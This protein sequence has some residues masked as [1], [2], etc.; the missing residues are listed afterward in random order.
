L[1]DWKKYYTENLYPLQN[2]VLNCVKN[3][4]TRFFLTGGTALSRGYF[5]HRYSDD[6]DFFTEND[7]EFR[8]Q[9]EIVMS[10]L[11]TS[12]FIIESDTI[13][14]SNDYISCYVKSGDYNGIK[15]KIDMVNDVA[16]RFGDIIETPVYFRTDDWRNILSNKLCALLRLEAKDYAD[17]LVISQ[18][19]I[20]NWGEVID[21]ARE[22]E[23]GLDPALLADLLV[24]I[25]KQHFDTI[26]WVIPQFWDQFK[27]DMDII[28]HDMIRGADNSL[29]QK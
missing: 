1:N 26:K 3:S 25:P 7:S 8:L 17:L 6:L 18:N 27:H 20:F 11:Q 2:G 9:A 23:I 29:I 22:K 4:G 5:N 15:L 19:R 21:E 24:S 12:G 28:L 10:G 13:V 16:K 14:I